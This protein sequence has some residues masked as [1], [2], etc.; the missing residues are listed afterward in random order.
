MHE[1]GL[2]YHFFEWKQAIENAY[3][4]QSPYFIEE[5]DQKICGVFP[6]AHLHNP[7]FKDQLVS[8]PYCD[9]G[10]ILADSPEIEKGLFEYA[11]Q[12]S[13]QNNI[14]KLEIRPAGTPCILQKP[15]QN[16][17]IRPPNTQPVP[18]K[19]N[20][21]PAKKVRM[22]LN[23]PEDSGLLL[24]SFKSKL[25]SQVN[26]PGRDGLVAKLGGLEQLNDFYPIYAENMRDLGSPAHSKDWFRNILKHFR[27]KAK[28]GIVFM[29]DKTPAAAGIILCHDRT[30]SIPWASSRK[31]FNRYNPNMLLY[32]T[33]L[34]F[35]ADNRYKFFDFGRSTPGEGT[36]K[37]KKQ[38]GARPHPLQWETW[39]IEKKRLHQISSDIN[40][41]VDGRVRIMAEK[42]IQMTPLAL[43]TFFGSRLRKYI[44]L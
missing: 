9:I 33:F 14:S 4:F 35:A 15:D 43:A 19:P 31:R 20:E 44:S 3:G 27:T 42:I 5:Q 7:I 8:L 23:L 32:W 28:C 40:Q 25:R 37:F 1:N 30:V 36:Y 21:I 26:K 12:Y 11:C 39:K 18:Q 16:K 10:G 38:W 6:T 17:I 24:A 29:P 13:K 2:A 41:N 34:Q 22:I